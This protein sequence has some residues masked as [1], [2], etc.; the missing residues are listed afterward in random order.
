MQ[1]GAGG[2][3]HLQQRRAVAVPVKAQ[4]G[5]L[6]GKSPGGSRDS[7]T[8]FALLQ[9]RALHLEGALLTA[10]GAEPS[11]V[12][13]GLL[14]AQGVGL[15][16]EQGLQGALGEAGGG[17]LGDLLHG[18][19]I[20]IESGAVVAE[21]AAGDDFAPL[22]GEVTEFLEFLGVNR[23]RAMMRPALELRTRGRRSVSLSG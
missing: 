11:A 22:G 23:R 4:D 5:P 13:T 1:A 19:E 9:L 7:G 21:G 20:D 18:V 16:F 17:G 10:E 3:D 12:G 8:R 2:N 14:L 15:L 6:G